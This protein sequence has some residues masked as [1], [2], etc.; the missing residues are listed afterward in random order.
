MEKSWS[1]LEMVKI[2][3]VENYYGLK[4]QST[5][6]IE[7]NFI[8]GTRPLKWKNLVMLKDVFHTKEVV[9]SGAVYHSDTAPMESFM[10][11]MAKCY[12]VILI[13]LGDIS[14]NM[15]L[16]AI[17]LNKPFIL[18][19]ENGLHD[20]I[21]DIAIFVDPQNPKDIQEKIIWLCTK[22]N[23]D[24]QVAKIKSFNFTHTWNDIAEEIMRI[25]KKI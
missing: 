24:A 16:D 19:R 18:T 14:P 2:D 21:K 25:Y 4:Q 8:G 6:P 10:K 20:R 9:A 1:N 12:A 11:K 3:I 5:E 13:S 17:R 15:I 22:E 23:Y 7:K